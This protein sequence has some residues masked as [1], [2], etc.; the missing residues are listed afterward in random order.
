MTKGPEIKVPKYCEDLRAPVNTECNSAPKAKVH[1]QVTDTAKHCL[2]AQLGSENFCKPVSFIRRVLT[3]PSLPG[4]DIVAL[5]PLFSRVEWSK[6]MA[7]EPVEI[8]PSV[9]QGFRVMT[10]DEWSARQVHPSPGPLSGGQAAGM[11]SWLLAHARHPI[12][13]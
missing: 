4:I 13:C 3:A 8:N 5:P 11:S 7:G 12:N 6:V 9:G 1:R 2:R 10:V